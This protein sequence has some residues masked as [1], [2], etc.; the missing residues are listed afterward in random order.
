MHF[1]VSVLSIHESECW[2]PRK[3]EALGS[4]G[5]GVMSH[6][7]LLGRKRGSSGRAVVFF[8]LSFNHSPI[9]PPILSVLKTA[10]VL[11]LPLSCERP[12]VT[13]SH[14]AFLLNG[15]VCG[16]LISSD[17]LCSSRNSICWIL[18]VWFR[19]VSTIS[20]VPK[21]IAFFLHM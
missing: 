7:G 12:C 5:P 20:C 17:F 3:T 18:C 2:L 16:L 19:R 4:S 6:Q 13:P 10:L 9:S 11:L 8:I 1:Y 15:G 14:L 21:P